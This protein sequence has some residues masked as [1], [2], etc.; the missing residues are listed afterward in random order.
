MLLPVPD[1]NTRVAALLSGQVD[2]IESPP[3]DTVPRLKSSGMQI[4]TNVYPHG[5]PYFLSFAEGSP[6]RDIRG[7]RR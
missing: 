4:V 5:W 3:P 6:M 2:W 7:A 1:P